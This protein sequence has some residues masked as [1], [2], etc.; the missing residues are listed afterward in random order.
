METNYFNGFNRDYLPK[1]KSR[2]IGCVFRLRENEPNKPLID[3]G[4]END[5]KVWLNL[6]GYAV[7]PVEYYYDLKEKAGD[8]VPE[9]EKVKDYAL[10]AFEGHP[11][12]EKSEW[13]EDCAPPEAEKPG[14]YDHYP[15]V[16]SPFS[17]DKYLSKKLLKHELTDGI[18]INTDYNRLVSL[19]KG[20]ERLCLAAEKAKF[21]KEPVNYFLVNILRTLTP[22]QTKVLMIAL[23]ERMPKTT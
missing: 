18:W 20:Y 4:T 9:N 16:G 17:V 23:T 3:A 15:D 21:E 8:P 12:K 5:G 7:M 2:M 13:T 10:A 6:V 22:D 14:E 19:F 1:R 11:M